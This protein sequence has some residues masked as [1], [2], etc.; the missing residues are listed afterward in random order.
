MHP[1]FD[2]Q[3]CKKLSF[4]ELFKKRKMAN[5]KSKSL[6]DESLK[7]E[8][9]RWQFS[10]IFRYRCCGILRFFGRRRFQGEICRS[11]SPNLQIFKKEEKLAFLYGK[12]RPSI[13]IF[14]LFFLSIF[15][16][17]PRATLCTPEL[18]SR[19]QNED[20]QRWSPSDQKWSF[21]IILTS[22]VPVKSP[23][24]FSTTQNC[25]KTKAPT[26]QIDKVN[27]EAHVTRI[28]FHLLTLI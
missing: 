4:L 8:I 11:K 16:A 24:R 23:V 27:F 3:V 14:L 9:R 10:C 15:L 21:L 2:G 20:F 13:M 26:K 5:F 7:I 22:K 19:T 12:I 1:Q 6:C 17:R 28:I 18:W 25:A